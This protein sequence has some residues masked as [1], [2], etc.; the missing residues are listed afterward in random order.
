MLTHR[1]AARVAL[2]PLRVVVVPPS[3]LPPSSARLG[4]IEGYLPHS[5][6]DY[7]ELDYVSNTTDYA[8]CVFKILCGGSGGGG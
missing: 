3:E 5:I 7:I 6:G 4:V 8:S 1:A 2:P